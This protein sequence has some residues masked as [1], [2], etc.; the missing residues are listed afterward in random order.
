M[1]D[2]SIFLEKVLQPV[3]LSHWRLPD[4]EGLDAEAEEARDRLLRYMERLKKVGPL[5]RSLVARACTRWS[6]GWLSRRNIGFCA[7]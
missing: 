5:S 1:Y 4:I 3:I 6:A 2:Y 7:L